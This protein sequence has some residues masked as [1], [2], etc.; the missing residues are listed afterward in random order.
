MLNLKLTFFVENFIFQFDISQVWSGNTNNNYNDDE[1]YFTFNIIQKYSYKIF[2]YARGLAM[3]IKSRF[4]W[5][6]RKIIWGFLRFST[7]KQMYTRY[8]SD[9]SLCIAVGIDWFGRTCTRT[10]RSMR[11]CLSVFFSPTRPPP[12]SSHRSIGYTSLVKYYAYFVGQPSPG[13]IILY[14]SSLIQNHHY[15]RSSSVMTCNILT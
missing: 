6:C 14:G 9:C 15:A 8:S 2:Y 1:M 11:I 13:H 7:R 5:T 12:D 3:K 4:A 10:W